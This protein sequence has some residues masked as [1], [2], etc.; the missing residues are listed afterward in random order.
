V[1]DQHL[2]AGATASFAAHPTPFTTATE[3]LYPPVP[4]SNGKPRTIDRYDIARGHLDAVRTA[5][6]GLGL[7]G[8]AISGPVSDD[9]VRELHAKLDA[10]DT[11]LAR[12]NLLWGLGVAERVRAD[13]TSARHD[14][15]AGEKAIGGVLLAGTVSDALRRRLAI[16]SARIELNLVLCD[17][18]D[19]HGIDVAIDLDARTLGFDRGAESDEVSFVR[20]IAKWE[21]GL[22][23]GKNTLAVV[24]NRNATLRPIITAYAR[25]VRMIP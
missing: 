2:V 10:A 20:G 22:A 15:K 21:T 18:A 19:G 1:K 12:A 8:V 24:A 9:D 5:I 6:A 17:L 4:F 23:S 13:C 25:G 11:D 7:G 14:L 3:L 16:M